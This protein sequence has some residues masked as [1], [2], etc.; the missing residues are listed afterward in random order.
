MRGY[1]ILK[2][3]KQGDAL[4]CIIF[5]M[6]MEPL[7]LNLENNP[8]ILPINTESMGDLP[9]V[10]AYADDV[11]CAISQTPESV[12]HVFN[13]YEKLSRRSGLILNADKTEL[14]LLGSDNERIYN[15]QYM[16]NNHLIKTK[17]KIKVNGISLQRN[18]EKIADD[19]ITGALARM[20]KFFKA[21]TRR[22]LSTLGRILIVKTF[23][24]SQCVYIMQSLTLSDR[25]YKLVNNLI[26][27]FIWNRHYLASKAPERIKREIMLKPIKFGGYGM[28]DVVALDESLKIKA[29]GRMLT[30]SHPFVTKIRT[31]CELKFFNPNCTVTCDPVITSGLKLLKIDRNKLW[32]EKEVESNRLF[33]SAIRDLEITKV[34]SRAGL[35]SIPYFMARQ[36]GVRR[37]GDLAPVDMQWLTRYIDKIKI[38]MIRKAVTVNLPRYRDELDY[39]LLVNK[40]FRNLNICTSKEIR[41]SRTLTNPVTVLKLGVTLTTNESLNW[42]LKISKLTSTKHK[43]VILRAAHG[44]VYTKERLHR[45]NLIDSNICPRCDQVET[46]QHKILECAY[47]NRIWNITETLQNHPNQNPGPALDRKSNVLGTLG[48]STIAS[49]TL[50]AEILLRILYLKDSQN[51]LVHPKVFVKQCLKS[52]IVKEKKLVIRDSV[53][54]LLDGLGD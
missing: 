33:I 41:E 37:L 12:Q 54:A 34:L 3:V 44:E 5:I 9:K 31:K 47:V 32:E 52:V 39:Q 24:I 2:G 36:R 28:L 11:N 16:G 13:E 21:W 35:N 20:D 1:N 48:N 8:E 45:F 49:M 15:I 10:Y 19:S 25:H 46:L 18:Y 51:Y 7:L 17:A 22:N 29:V 42:G 38:P 40:K 43:N 23:G 50:N 53:K 30:S 27:K 26:Y 14:L 4:S 6:S